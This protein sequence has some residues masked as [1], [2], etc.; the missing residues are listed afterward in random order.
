[1]L[2]LMARYFFTSH[3]ITCGLR[4]QRC[5][6]ELLVALLPTNRSMWATFGAKWDSPISHAC[7]KM[8]AAGYLHWRQVVFQCID[9]M[10]KFWI[11]Q[12]FLLRTISCDFLT[13]L[14]DFYWTRTDFKN[15]SNDL[16]CKFNIF[17]QFFCKN[18]FIKLYL[19]AITV[20]FHYTSTNL[21]ILKFQLW[22]NDT[23]GTFILQS[24]DSHQQK[25][26]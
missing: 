1:M 17:Y 26:L 6:N 25:T 13:Y 20:Q 10:E 19:S 16:E 11:F 22:F 24:N 3:P 15:H 23:N 5:T 12:L 21:D 18:Y 9:R 7:Q 8:S 14:S 2:F 4:N